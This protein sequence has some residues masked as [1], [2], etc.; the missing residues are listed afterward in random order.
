MT[1]HDDTPTIEERERAERELESDGWIWPPDRDVVAI[2]IRANRL[3]ARCASAEAEVAS[4]KRER[5]DQWHAYNQANT[6]ALR[7]RAERAEA[8]R[9]ELWETAVDRASI[10]SALRDE[11]LGLRGQVD[12]LYAER[13]RTELAAL[14]SPAAPVGLPVMSGDD[15]ADV[16]TQA[17]LTIDQV[18]R[19]IITKERAV[20]VLRA[21]LAVPDVRA[22]EL[23]DGFSL[24]MC[25]GADSPFNSTPDIFSY[26]TSLYEPRRAYVSIRPDWT[27]MQ[28][29]MLPGETEAILRHHLSRPLTGAAP[30][31]GD[32]AR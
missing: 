11:V 10:I 1:D 29:G 20:T 8:E 15:A 14:R 26:E 27:I 22:P 6:G 31:E 28:A 16:I 2:Q 24:R 23:P 19:E 25:R 32:D 30:Q 21:L 7:I 9:D 3:A 13:R 4:L 17:S 5:D 12:A 18:C